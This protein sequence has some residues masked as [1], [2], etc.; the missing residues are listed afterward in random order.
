MRCDLTARD[1]H[2]AAAALGLGTA[3]RAGQL[4]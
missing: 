1:V 3:L 4:A 2:A